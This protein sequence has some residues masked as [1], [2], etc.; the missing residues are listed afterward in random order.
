MF[1]LTAYSSTH[2]DPIF[3]S[4]PRHH[5]EFDAQDL[6]DALDGER[7]V[8]VWFA[9]FKAKVDAKANPEK[10]YLIKVDIECSGGSEYGSESGC[11]NTRVKT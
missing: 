6:A 11:E 5:R 10:D 7:A 2:C 1:R 9:H 4:P 3:V 8:E